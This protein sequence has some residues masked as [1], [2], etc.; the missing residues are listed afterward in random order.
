MK[1][2]DA[3]K[4]MGLGAIGAFALP[5]GKANAFSTE[6]PPKKEFKTARNGWLVRTDRFIQTVDPYYGCHPFDCIEYPMPYVGEMEVRCI[7]KGNFF[8][9][10]RPT[11][12]DITFS[13]KSLPGQVGNFPKM[14]WD[15][16]HKG[17]EREFVFVRWANYEILKCW[18]FSGFLTQYT[19]TATPAGWDFKYRF[20]VNTFK[21]EKSCVSL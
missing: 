18:R 11:Y 8:I 12:H 19:E 13:T 14:M 3:L 9:P 6:T 10:P 20:M 17:E 15:L 21:E 2:R 5:Q 1:R 16:L 7:N 4:I